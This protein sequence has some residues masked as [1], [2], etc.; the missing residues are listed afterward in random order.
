MHRLKSPTV[1][2]RGVGARPVEPVGE[3]LQ[4]LVGLLLGRSGPVLCVG[5][6]RVPPVV[7]GAVSS[8]DRH[9]GKPAD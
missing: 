3:A 9:A 5:H 2:S 6:M 8:H 4:R 1:M 7:K